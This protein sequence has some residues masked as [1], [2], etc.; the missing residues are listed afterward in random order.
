M[1]LKP[2]RFGGWLLLQH[3]LAYSDQ[4]S[5]LFCIFVLWRSVHLN[6]NFI[7][8][9]SRSCPF[10]LL[11]SPFL[12]SG[13]AGLHLFHFGRKSSVKLDLEPASQHLEWINRG[14]YSWDP[15]FG[16]LLLRMMCQLW[17][18]L[19]KPNIIL[20]YQVSSSSKNN[21]TSELP[22]SSSLTPTSTFLGV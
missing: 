14:Y 1:L 12:E 7:N 5:F 15:R 16:C 22:G 3:V 11:S 4:F 19:R 2:L 20:M 17:N 13:L 10:Q 21:K 18:Y 9:Y 6:H 8:L